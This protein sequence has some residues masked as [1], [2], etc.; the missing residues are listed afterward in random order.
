[1]TAGFSFP[2]AVVAATGP[3]PV[4]LVLT[5][6]IDS[7]VTA[8]FTEAGGVP[9]PPYV[10]P[11]G[12]FTMTNTMATNPAIPNMTVY[13]R[14]NT[15][16][17]CEHSICELGNPLVTAQPANLGAYT[18]TISKGGATLQTISVPQHFWFS[19][20][21]WP[22]SPYPVTV[23]VASLI[24]A[25]WLPNYSSAVLGKYSKDYPS[26][27]YT[28]MT[29][30]GLTGNMGQTG[31][32]GDIGLVTEWQADYICNGTNEATVFAQAEAA[33]TFPWNIRDPRTGA[34]FDAQANPQATMAFVNKS[35]PA[36]ILTTACKIGAVP[37]ICDEA[38]EPELAY[39]PFLL[40]GDPY[41][42][43]TMQFQASSNCLN[44]PAA[45]RYTDGLG[46]RAVAWGL[47]TAARLASV[48]PASVPSWLLP[49]SVWQTDLA[50]RVTWLMSAGPNGT[51]AW[52]TLF[53]VLNQVATS[54]RPPQWDFWQGD[55]IAAACFDALRIG[56]TSVKPFLDWYM[57]QII[58]RTNGTSG[59][60][61]EHP[62]PYNV[63]M[64]SSSLAPLATNWTG[65][66]SANMAYQPTVVPLLPND[67]TGNLYLNLS[68]SGWITY[69]SYVRGVLSMAVA[70]GD[71][72]AAAAPFAWI[73][74]EFVRQLS[75]TLQ[76][77][78]KWLM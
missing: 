23:S 34:P 39:L 12:R 44:A 24:A 35:L 7:G 38:H 48:T 36:T 29:L 56:Q 59:W 20:W 62:S 57:P 47:R 68:T 27:T 45:A 13:F 69:D 40:T 51:N 8:Q 46:V 42:L 22:Q 15:D 67:P 11:Q 21:R 58:A 71:Y 73:Q 1:M 25:G 10:D 30:A 33:G 66:W 17:S 16:G 4:G 5:V 49:A 55:F 74:G 32:R 53:Q 19:R 54:N 9:L 75:P 31:E 61:R 43:E 28:P 78:R 64:A 70:S 72:P 41:H 52:N 60:L 26:Q 76:P 37:V 14:R 63:F 18:A 3:P 77:D 6:A 50:H 65:L 2:F